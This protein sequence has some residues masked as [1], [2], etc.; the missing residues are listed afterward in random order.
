MRMDQKRSDREEF[1]NKKRHRA[2]DTSSARMTASQPQV[3]S[4]QRYLYEKD[5]P[6]Y[7]Q[8]IEIGFFSLDSQRRFYNDDRQLRYYVEAESS[9]NFNLRDGYRDRYIKRD[10]S[11]KEKLDHMLQWILEN[12]GKVEMAPKVEGASASSRHLKFD[13]VTWRG[14]LT[15]ILTTPYETHEGWLLAVTLFQGTHYISEVET[16]AARRERED[17]SA[18]H[19]EMTY[20]GYK[21]EQYMCADEPGGRP[22]SGGTVNTNEAYC[23][24]VQTRL[25]D[26]HLLFSGEVDCKDNGS[27]LKTAPGCYIELKTSLEICNPKQQSNFLR[28]KL[29]KWWAQS[30]LPGVPRIVAGFRNNSGYVVSTQ[31]YETGKISQMIKAEQNCWRPT[32]CM[33]FCAEFLSFIK[34]VV[35]LDDPRVVYLFSWDPF[36]DVCYSVHRDSEYSFL[37]NWYV[38]EM[39]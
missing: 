20:W 26:H 29:L 11:I 14:H 15:K 38:E 5:F 17:R 34:K 27:P 7:K 18:R 35:I 12:R 1:S 3:L 13:F 24:V 25:T 23:T 22:D 30:F 31:T 32:V 36:K 37:P 21:F 19:E 28:F 33:N 4:V 8:P 2:D 10:E 6:L 39:R 16:E 9:P